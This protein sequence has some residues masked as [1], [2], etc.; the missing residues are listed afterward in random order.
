MRDKTRLLARLEHEG[1]T[2]LSAKLRPCG[3]EWPMICLSCGED[4]MGHQR[5]KRKWCPRC[6][7]AIAAERNHRLAAA[8]ETFQWPL[9]L[10]LTMRNVDD[11]SLGA[12]R[13]LRRSFGKMRH[14]KWWKA[15][16]RAGCACIEITNEGKGW[17]PHLHAVLDC[18]FLSVTLKSPHR[19]WSRAQK[20][21]HF[22]EAASE[23]G[24]K[25]AK[26]LGQPVASIRI[27]RAFKAT[28][29]KE[30]VKYSVKGSD[31]IECQGRIGGAI[32]ALEGTRLLTTF[33]HCHGRVRKQIGPDRD[34]ADKRSVN[35]EGKDG[36]APACNHRGDCIP[37]DVFSRMLDKSRT[38]REWQ[39]L[40][41]NEYAGIGASGIVFR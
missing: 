14:T 20:A 24:A 13:T 37:H 4:V 41:R 25:W 28:I 11:L 21:K 36:A 31:L 29:L 30:V 9:F 26:Y 1:E 6:A 22:K 39:S 32:R 5:C 12:I 10:T 16:V 7:P 35:P 8:V 17:H 40:R 2:D 34:Q 23:L 18:E 33:G 15:R 3:K 19:F 27:K 38:T